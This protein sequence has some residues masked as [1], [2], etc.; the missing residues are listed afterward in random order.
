MSLF[1][2]IGEA[3]HDI[4]IDP[5]IETADVKI[6]RVSGS[7]PGANP[8]D[9]PTDVFQIIRLHAVVFTEEAE[10]ANGT[11]VKERQDVVTASPTATVIEEDGDSVSEQIALDVSESDEVLIDGDVR[12]IV[13]VTRTPAA[14]D[15]IAVW[16]IRVSD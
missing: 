10:Y 11:L 4:L 9:P 15:D 5:D 2:E 1:S 16:T 6:R 3:I 13:S 12:R 14:G 8:W 7:I